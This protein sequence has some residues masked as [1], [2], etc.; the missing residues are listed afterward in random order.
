MTMFCFFL[1]AYQ[2]S[3]SWA[4]TCAVVIAV[5]VVFFAVY[6]YHVVCFKVKNRTETGY[7]F[8]NAFRFFFPMTES[9]GDGNHI[10]F[11]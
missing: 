9:I 7:N 3:Q 2:I 4:S 10:F 1:L 11:L 5:L 6:L 8:A